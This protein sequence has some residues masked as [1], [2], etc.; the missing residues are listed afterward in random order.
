[1]TM[2]EIEHVLSCLAEECCEVGQRVSKALR[3][4]LNEVQEGQEMS[5]AERIA[6]EFKDLI[7]IG[8]MLQSN[9]V[10]PDII[11]TEEEAEAKVAKVLKYIE[12]AKQQ[13]TVRG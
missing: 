5:N 11:P 13:G 2:T 4:G 6:Y 12:Y 8:Y 10:L 7:T 9:G 3:F 1:M